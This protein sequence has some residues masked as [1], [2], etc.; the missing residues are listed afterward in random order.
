M[1]PFNNHLII[2]KILIILYHSYCC[3]LNTL[4]NLFAHSSCTFLLILLLC[5]QYTVLHIISLLHIL[6]F[7]ILLFL[8]FIFYFIFFPYLYLCRF[9]CV[10]ISYNCTVHG[11]D[12]TY[13]SLLIIFC[14]IVYVTNTNLEF[15]EGC[16]G[17]FNCS[18]NLTHTPGDAWQTH[19][20]AV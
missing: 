7:S 14:I 13:I 1:T 20:I 11:A 4:Y 15:L 17:I 6:F 8:L 9:T 2:C 18:P 10:C 3:Y 19:S 16:L 5:L 12:L